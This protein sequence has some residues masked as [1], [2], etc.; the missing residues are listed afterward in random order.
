M[1]SRAYNTLAQEDTSF[2]L[3]LH[4]VCIKI[5]GDINHQSDVLSFHKSLK[6]FEVSCTF[7]SIVIEENVIVILLCDGCL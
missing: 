2:L 7:A 6:A 1:D 3:C 4:N 5:F